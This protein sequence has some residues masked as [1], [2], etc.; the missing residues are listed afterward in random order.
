MTAESVLSDAA[1]V[2]FTLGGSW[3]AVV[4]L[5]SHRL[6]DRQVALTGASVLTLV[7]GAAFAAGVW[8]GWGRSL[9]A[10]GLLAGAYFVLAVASAGGVGMGD[11]KFA[12]V[13]GLICGWHGW[14]AVII[15]TVATFLLAAVVGVALLAA[16][17]VTRTSTLA[18]GP[19]MVA[20][21]VLALAAG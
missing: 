12:S 7:T 10:A 6:P 21:T 9:L 17:R 16:D 8:T 19:F 3:L 18:F 13:V 15:S 11:V 2:V 4:D 20:G 1:T 14:G 5:R